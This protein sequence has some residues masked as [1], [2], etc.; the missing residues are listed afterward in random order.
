[1]ANPQWYQ[2]WLNDLREDAREFGAFMA[3]DISSKG[4]LQFHYQ[5]FLEDLRQ[6]IDEWQPANPL[7]LL[8]RGTKAVHSIVERLAKK[9]DIPTD[10]NPTEEEID[11][12]GTLYGVPIVTSGLKR[13]LIQ[14][15]VSPRKIVFTSLQA[16][17]EYISELPIGVIQGIEEIK[18]SDGKII[19]FRVWVS[20]SS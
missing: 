11:T 6:L 17:A 16:L 13:L 14:S 9:Y 15:D 1:M 2:D 8:N 7:V 4:E 10:D 18:N 12:S 5:Q 20:S 3:D 19:G